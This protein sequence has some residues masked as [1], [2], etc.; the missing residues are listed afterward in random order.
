MQELSVF[1]NGDAS[2]LPTARNV[3]ETGELING[4]WAV[5]DLSLQLEVMSTI[6]HDKSTAIISQIDCPWPSTVELYREVRSSNYND[7]LGL[8]LRYHIYRVCFPIED[9]RL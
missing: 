5:Y 3:P 2:Y 6:A 1:E 4:F 7:I 9:G 8:P